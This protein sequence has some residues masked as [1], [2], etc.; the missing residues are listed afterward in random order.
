MNVAYTLLI[1]DDERQ[2]RALLTELLKDE[3]RLIL[4]KNGVQ[5]LERAAEHKPDLILLDVLMPE[6]DGYTVIRRLKNDE[7]TRDIPVIFVSALDSAESEERGL[8]LG[9]VDYISKPFRPSIVRARVRNHIQSVHQRRLLEQ[10]ALLDALTEIPNRRRFVQVYEQEWRR[11]KRHGSALSLIV[12]DVDHFKFYN[13][14]HGHTAGDDV[15]RQVGHTLRAALKRSSDFVARYG[16]EEFVILLPEV[17]REGAH[18]LAEQVRA[19]IEL[20]RIPHPHSPVQPW[21]TI[22]LGGAT[23]TPDDGQSESELF[24]VADSALYEA[25]RTGRNRVV[26]A[27]PA[28]RSWEGETV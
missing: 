24:S 25:K 28:G 18:A 8:E 7:S 9:A 16:G 26:W 20:L 13:D 3:Y 23:E 11:C 19:E 1:V 22:S 12:V 2:N 17:D 21:I 14:N 5:A 4:A 15:L 6:M 10:L 27:T